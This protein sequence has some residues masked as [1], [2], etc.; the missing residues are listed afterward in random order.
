MK[1]RSVDV[2]SY[3][4]LKLPTL[5]PCV[6]ISNEASLHT[7]REICAEMQSGPATKSGVYDSTEKV[8]NEY[9]RASDFI[10][11]SKETAKRVESIIT[12]AVTRLCAHQISAKSIWLAEPLQFLCYRSENS[13]HF[14]MHTDN[15][16]FDAEG[17]FQYTSPHRVLTAVLYLNDEFE[18]GEIEFGSVQDDKGQNLKFK[19][20]PGVLTVFPSDLRF[21]HE[22]KPV[23]SGTRYCVVS[24]FNVAWRD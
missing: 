18:G 14:N 12:S 1:L 6:I 23:I 11:V 13:G 19:P 3:G 22:A 4:D 17:R 21:P 24:W 8:V 2:S 15:A 7:C 16:Y 20:F 5:S 10:E 9:H